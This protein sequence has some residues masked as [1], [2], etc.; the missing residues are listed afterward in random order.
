MI[1]R[2]YNR[3]V[4][5]GE[6]IWLEIPKELLCTSRFVKRQL[7]PSRQ[8]FTL[9]GVTLH[10]QLQTELGRS[11]R[12]HKLAVRIP[13]AGPS[14]RLLKDKWYIHVHQIKV[15]TSGQGDTK[16]LKLRTRRLVKILR[17][18]FGQNYHPRTSASRKYHGSANSKKNYRPHS[19]DRNTAKQKSVSTKKNLKLTRQKQNLTP[20]LTT[21]PMPMQAPQPWLNPYY[22]LGQ[23]QATNQN[24][25][26]QR[27]LSVNQR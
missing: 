16:W 10:H 3:V 9:N 8:Y 21:Y 2:G 27:I 15:A 6:S 1:S 26:A 17:K 7:T 4:T 24:V 22:Y 5:D 18:T 11:P 19:G 13:R 20:T 25:H 12:R 14:S 23:N